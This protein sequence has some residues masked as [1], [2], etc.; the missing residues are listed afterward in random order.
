MENKQIWALIVLVVV[1]AGGY[2]FFGSDQAVNNNTQESD[3]TSNTSVNGDTQSKNDETDDSTVTY[4]NSGYTPESL[5]VEAGT[6]VTFVNESNLPMWVATDVHP[7]HAQYPG[8]SIS[9]CDTDEESEIFDACRGLDEGSTYSFEFNE[10]GS[11]EYHDHLN[12][13]R[14]GTIIVE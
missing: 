14:T 1:G 3:V 11:W 10:P 12:P 7:V 13:S 2:L 4:T 5:I 8:S 6:T 9:K